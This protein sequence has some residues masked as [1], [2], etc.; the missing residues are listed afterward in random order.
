MPCKV[1][2]VTDERALSFLGRGA[3]GSGQRSEQFLPVGGQFLCSFRVLPTMKFR[4]HDAIAIRG[5]FFEPQQRTD[6]GRRQAHRLDPRSL[7]RRGDRC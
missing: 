3:L 7:E 4:L 1:Q 2:A 5:S 6:V